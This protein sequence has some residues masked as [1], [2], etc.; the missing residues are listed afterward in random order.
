V[1]KLVLVVCLAANP[2]VCKE[3]TPT[4]DDGISCA[5]QGQIVAQDWLSGHPK[6][7]LRG[8]RCRFGTPE[9]GA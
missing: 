2:G 3:V 5:I 9:R 8:W 7:T 4:L 6:W 1:I